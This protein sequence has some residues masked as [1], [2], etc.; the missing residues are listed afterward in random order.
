MEDNGISQ[1]WLKVAGEPRKA[2]EPQGEAW[3]RQKL[4][5]LDISTPQER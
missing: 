3:E 1:S 2:K 4:R 5:N